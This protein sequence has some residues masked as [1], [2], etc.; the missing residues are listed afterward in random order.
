MVQSRQNTKL[1]NK[2]QSN[3]SEEK[4]KKGEK[5]TRQLEQEYTQKTNTNNTTKR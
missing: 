1:A 3:T 2:T 4:V 5:G